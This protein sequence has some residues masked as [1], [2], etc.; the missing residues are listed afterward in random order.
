[1]N[2]KKLF[3]TTLV[4]AVICQLSTVNRL[5]AGVGTSGAQFLKIGVSA[6]SSALGEAGAASS[7]AES[8][9]INPAGL[10]GSDGME[11]RASQ[12]MWLESINY[13]NIAFAKKIGDNALGVGI[14]YLSVPAITK[15]DNTG[16]ILADSY[17]PA[18]MAVSL[19]YAR[20]FKALFAGITLKYI[21]STLDDKT[22]T[23]IAADVG[24]QKVF[25]DQRFITGLA[26]Q[27]LGTTMKFNF[28][29]D[30]LPLNVKL[31]GKYAIPFKNSEIDDN[32]NMS[33]GMNI[34]VDINSTND[35]GFYTNAGAEYLRKFNESTSA[36]VRAGYKSSVTKGLTGSGISAGFGISY[37]KYVL[38]YAYAPYGDLG[39]TSRV[40]LS[41]KF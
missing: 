9:F 2:M 32:L 22:A 14:N 25:K 38:D 19:C 1:M 21:S 28:E 26:V 8:V 29:E 40:S 12:A 33:H 5:Y 17:A 16:T 31:G 30:P 39:Q 41:Y 11:I 3:F 6:N 7:G 24:A 27:N 18:D 34:L 4:F 13:S 23:A 15:V 10:V 35:T 37:Q 36:A 20:D